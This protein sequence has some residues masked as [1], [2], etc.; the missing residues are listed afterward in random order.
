LGCEAWR[1]RA[2]AGIA[3]GQFRPAPERDSLVWRLAIAFPLCRECLIGNCETK[4]HQRFD[5]LVSFVSELPPR[6]AE[7]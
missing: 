3:T 4:P 2:V 5:F 1:D 6:G 7:P